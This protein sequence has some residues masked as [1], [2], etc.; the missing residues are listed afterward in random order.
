M[1]CSAHLVIEA[2][3]SEDGAGLES[4]SE[5]FVRADVAVRLQEG[6]DRGVVEALIPVS[7][8]HLQHAVQV[9]IQIHERLADPVLIAL[10]IAVQTEV[11][12]VV[13]V[14]DR[15]EPLLQRRREP[16]PSPTQLDDLVESIYRDAHPERRAGVKALAFPGGGEGAWGVRGMRTRTWGRL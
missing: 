1:Q 12:R 4:L 10:F 13:A 11:R 9:G 8:V 7:Q 6:D 3:K 5:R 2:T 14:E 16:K 15:L